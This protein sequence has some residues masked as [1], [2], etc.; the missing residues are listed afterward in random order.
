MKLAAAAAVPLAAAICAGWNA[1]ADPLF[2]DGDGIGPANG[3]SGQWDSGLIRWSKTQGGPVDQQ[4]VD[5][6]DA[7]FIGP[8]GTVY[9]PS[10]PT[11]NS[12][13]VSGGNYFFRG[14]P[15]T[16]S[17]NSG[18]V[19]VNIAAGSDAQFNQAI[20]GTQ[21]FTKT[22]AGSI[23]FFSNV[24]TSGIVDIQ[25]GTVYFAGPNGEL[26]DTT[27]VNV[28]ANGVLDLHRFNESSFGGVTGNGIVKLA[29]LPY[30][31]QN[32]G[33]LFGITYN[34]TSQT[35]VFSGS[36][37]GAGPIPITGGRVIKQGVGTVRLEGNN[38]YGFMSIRLGTLEVRGGHALAD[39]AP[40][41][42]TD[43]TNGAN[44]NILS[45][46]TIG[47]LGGGGTASAVDLGA[48]GDVTLSMG[49]DGMYNV[50]AGAIRGTGLIVKTGPAVQSINLA[51]GQTSTYSGKFRIE[52]GVLA[53]G[54][55]PAMG[56]LTTPQ[57]DNFTLA[58]GTLANSVN[59]GFTMG[60]NRGI[61]VVADSGIK[62]VGSG[63]STV[64][65]QGPLTGSNA[66]TKS[67]PGIL[68]ISSDPGAT[69]SGKWVVT[70]GTLRSSRGI[71]APLGTGS[72]DLSGGTILLKPSS[73]GLA[74]AQ[75]LA[76]GV[77]GTFAF[78]PGANLRVERG[79]NTSYTLTIG[80][81]ASLPN[82]ALQRRANGTLV[83]VAKSGVNALGDPLNGEQVLVNGG[84]S[85]TNGIVPGVFGVADH[86]TNQV[87]DFLGYDLVAGFRKAAYS[88]TD[89]STSTPNDV[90][91]QSANVT[92]AAPANAYALKVGNAGVPATINATGQTLN[93]GSGM[94]ILNDG[95]GIS[96]GTLAFGAAQGV[97]QTPG[98]AANLAANVTGS[99]ALTKLGA[100]TLTLTSGGTLNNT[101]P[102]IIS[103]GTL[104]VSLNNQL[105]ANSDLV[106]T[107]AGGY[108]TT[109]SDTTGTVSKLTLNGT[110][111]HVKTL[112]SDA[113]YLKSSSGSTPASTDYGPL[114]DFGVNGQLI[115]GNGDST[116]K[117]GAVTDGTSTSSTL[118]KN[119]TGTLTL[120][121]PVS[122]GTGNIRSAAM[123]YN[124]LWIS[125]GGA[126]SLSSNNSVPNLPAAL[127]PDTY[128]LDNGTLIITSLI[129][130]NI[131]ST[132]SSFFDPVGSRRGITVGPGGGTFVV[133]NPLEIIVANGAS[134]NLYG[135]GVFTKS[136]PGVWRYSTNNPNFTGKTLI[137][138][139]T[140]QLT[141]EL[142]GGVGTGTDYITLDGGTIAVESSNINTWDPSRGMTVAAG[143]GEVRNSLQWVFA[144]QLSGSGDLRKNGTGN[145]IVTNPLNSGYT[146][147]ITQT[148]GTIDVRDNSVLGTGKITFD[149]QFPI[150]LLRASGTDPI[151][152]PNAI[153]FKPGST[154]DIRPVGPIILS[155]KVSG[156]GNI[157]K[158][159]ALAAATGNLTFS[160]PAN[161]F[162]GNMTATIGQVT[163]TANGAM[164]SPAGATI[165][166]GTATFALDGGAGGTLNYTVPE[167][168]AI[169]G[170]GVGGNGAFQN[171]LGNNTFA[172][173]ISLTAPTSIGVNIDSLDLTG[174]ITGQTTLNK[175]GLGILTLSNPSS[176]IVGDL[177]IEA[178]N[179]NF[180]ANH[181]LGGQLIPKTG[182]VVTLTPGNRVLRTT[183]VVFNLDN[184]FNP[185]AKLD[186]TNGRLIVDYDPNTN[187]N[188]GFF[189]RNAI[190]AAY[191]VGPGPHW[192]GNGIT[193]S[194]AQGNGALAVGYAEA[195]D[196]FGPNGGTW[197]G[198]SV[199]GSSFLVRTTL[200][201]DTNLD[202]AV[203]FN[204][205]VALA[206]HYGDNSGAAPWDQGDFTYDG[207]IDFNDLVKL[208]Q[209]YGGTFPAAGVPGASVPFDQDLA[210][211]FASVPEPGTLS[212]VALGATAALGRRR[213]RSDK[214]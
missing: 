111:Q 156:S 142:S 90:V 101:G 18:T 126:V 140:I 41:F 188:A 117:G 44:L 102:T 205:L 203:N 16:F 209:N 105:S 149:P 21:G 62:V 181:A 159:I 57:T 202:G 116:Y 100:G 14:L 107:S 61:T 187:P 201:G 134:N 26:T 69:F 186:L 170:D 19:A 30:I 174:P 193:S 59:G 162:T 95:A 155:G 29:A 115:V 54:S 58:G 98:N 48:A 17:A 114:I 53:F 212:L 214:R 50:Y 147:N 83:L 36:I 179:L 109:A 131:G 173:P 5:G 178:G 108:G 172:G 137:K 206:Q 180:N 56:V 31:A 6:S 93:V 197:T 67:G 68:D 136:G 113:I 158:G 25:Q 165:V 89:V 71:G 12:L 166:Q 138:R 171:I 141:G 119:G 80:S 76:S 87:G 23:G 38:T 176:K 15:V 11:V 40:V 185:D 94:V 32:T 13:N 157:Y 34:D 8:G 84:V 47:S 177:T 191:G 195:S 3:G 99:G 55:E 103:H 184:N 175:K 145:W 63:V 161:D 2:W 169:Q 66:L 196:L 124:K 79:A 132:N 133:T 43:S 123:S 70:E 183:N 33:S 78:G 167:P 52:G 96:G 210:R 24:V 42:I 104:A 85:P 128:N 213:R 97:I 118:W 198:E 120:G 182:T 148:A 164:G 39:D 144:G 135:T 73:S 163:A 60:S 200:A 82:T 91:E 130:N 150:G 64:T 125:G 208:A 88:S 10:T 4:Y 81:G 154:I 74:I 37:Q 151:T 146:G 45:S 143:G 1:Q 190:V 9:T 204:D 35:Q 160:N 211:A 139:G 51:T 199:D 127:T 129:P 28:G 192:T 46:E 207:N 49:G 112:S 65:V 77:G 194:T 168:L 22:G 75:T 86:L 106:F 20:S 152:L 110:T 153:E 189:I 92:L 72:I 27:V 121:E 122:P 7:N